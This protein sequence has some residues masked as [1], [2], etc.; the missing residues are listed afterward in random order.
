MPLDSME[1]LTRIH[2]S[3]VSDTHWC[4]HEIDHVLVCHK[5]VTIAPNADEVR[6]TVY[7]GK[8]ELRE[9]VNNAYNKNILLTP[10]F[11]YICRSFLF[12]WW[13]SLHDLHLFKDDKIHRA[14]QQ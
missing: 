10:W 1:F 7:L 9:F 8:E 11:K 6:H 2:Y 13:D 12:D 4:E 14:G 3:G 5:D